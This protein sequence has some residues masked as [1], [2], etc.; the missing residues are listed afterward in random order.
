[1]PNIFISVQNKRA[2]LTT[3]IVIVNGNSDYLVTFTFDSEWDD[4]DTKTLEV[5]YLDR[6]CVMRKKEVLF[7]GSA[8]SL[9]ILRDV[10]EVAIGVYAGNLHTTT[11]ALIQCEK[12]ISDDDGVHDPPYPDVYNQLLEYLAGLQGG[13]VHGAAST[14]INGVVSGSVHGTA[15]PLEV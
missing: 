9:P 10:S 2:V 5:K 14:R 4:Y 13:T 3:P 15:E 6:N 11:G 7:E 12:C 8:V 1:M